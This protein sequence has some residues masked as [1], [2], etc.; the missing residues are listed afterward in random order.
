MLIW[1]V[2]SLTPEIRSSILYIKNARELWVE[3]ATRYTRSDGPRVYHLEKSL[4]SITQGANSIA[5]YYANFKT[6]W[7]EFLAHRS[8]NKCT[9]GGSADLIATQ[10][11]DGVMK[12]LVGL[13]ESYATIR[14]QLL[15]QVPVPTLAKVYSILLQEEGHRGLSSD[16]VLT[17]QNA[18]AML[19][20]TP[21]DISQEAIACLAKNGYFKAQN[22]DNNRPKCTHCGIVGHTIKS[23][24]Q[25]IGYPSGWQGS[26]GAR[27]AQGYHQA[28]AAVATNNVYHSMVPNGYQIQPMI[29]GPSDMLPDL[30]Q[31]LLQFTQ[32]QAHLNQP[33]TSQT[34]VNPGNSSPVHTV[35]VAVSEIPHASAN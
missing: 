16:A 29:Q 30:Y 25:V 5:S 10:H 2:N 12:F 23:Y 15:M 22:K 21:H 24:Y 31:Q 35:A 13:N 20:Q 26:K 27:K 17:S 14:S 33:S 19:S 9:C 18:M 3:L 8:V 11:N 7:D 6:I 1:L 28:H 4:G 32:F 34:Q